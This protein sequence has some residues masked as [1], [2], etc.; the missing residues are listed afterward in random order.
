MR[1][2]QLLLSTDLEKAYIRVLG[3]MNKVYLELV[4]TPCNNPAKA[5]L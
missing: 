4:Y 2:S 3:K 1:I 5:L